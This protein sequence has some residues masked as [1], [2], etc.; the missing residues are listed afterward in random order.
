MGW[1][2]ES[3][4]YL[5]EWLL[6]GRDPDDAGSRLGPG[7]AGSN[8]EEQRTGNDERKASPQMPRLPYAECLIDSKD[9]SLLDGRDGYSDDPS[10][11][12]SRE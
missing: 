3:E 4:C 8:G 11:R 10:F 1:R 12:A 9:Q 6:P 2:T 5:L 7:E